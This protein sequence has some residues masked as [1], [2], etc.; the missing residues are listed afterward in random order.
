MIEDQSVD[1]ATFEDLRLTVA[2]RGDCWLASVE[3]IDDPAEISTMSD[4]TDYVNPEAAK[5]AAV[6]IAKEL[7][8]TDVPE[9]ELEWRGRRMSTTV[10]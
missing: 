2:K 9:D 5:R 3:D 4:G 7:F 1:S 6:V 8:G 10:R